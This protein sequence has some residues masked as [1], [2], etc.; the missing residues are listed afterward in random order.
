MSFQGP[1]VISNHPVE[2]NAYASARRRDCHRATR[3]RFQSPKNHNTLWRV[4]QTRKSP[5]RAHDL[6]R[7]LNANPLDSLKLLRYRSESALWK[8]VSK[9]IKFLAN[10]CCC[11]FP[12]SSGHFALF[13]SPLSSTSASTSYAS[14]KI[15]SSLWSSSFGWSGRKD[16]ISR[17]N[18]GRRESGESIQWYICAVASYRENRR[19]ISLV[20]CEFSEIGQRKTGIKPRARS[21]CAFVVRND[22][23]TLLRLYIIPR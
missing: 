18:R 15:S 7:R 20:H 8:Y 23:S 13:P 21:R 4:A 19:G 5:E 9:N 22:Q 3:A 17:R 2:W 16:F 6:W 1:T 10:G 11:C 14:F 12:R